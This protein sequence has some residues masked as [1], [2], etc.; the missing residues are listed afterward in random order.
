M[1]PLVRG[2]DAHGIPDHDEV[3]IERRVPISGEGRT[4][5]LT[6]RVDKE[7]A[8]INPRPR[9]TE[10]M[11]QRNES[12]S[13]IAFTGKELGPTCPACLSGIEPTVISKPELANVVREA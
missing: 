10:P 5:S 1:L 12:T 3:Q 7:R 2:R 9:R 13:K 4:E 8:V 11:K 6:V